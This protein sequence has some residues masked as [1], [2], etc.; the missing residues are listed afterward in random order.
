MVS[1][2]FVGVAEPSWTEEEAVEGGGGLGVDLARLGL[3]LV[4]V[5]LNLAGLGLNLAGLGLDI[6]GLFVDRGSARGR[7]VF[8]WMTHL[9]MVRRALK[10]CPTISRA[11]QLMN[12]IT[13]NSSSW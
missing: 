1:S 3:N 2:V 9:C 12:Y 4:G 10:S 7:D 8:W 6:L 5:G 13:R 11:V